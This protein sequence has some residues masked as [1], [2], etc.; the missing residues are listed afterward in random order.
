MKIAIAVITVLFAVAAQAQTPA[1]FATLDA[2]GKVTLVAG[3][4]QVTAPDPKDA[5]VQIT[6]T[7]R[8]PDR[9]IVRV[10]RFDPATGAQLGAND[11][12]FSIS[13]MEADIARMQA[14]LAAAQ[15]QLAK[16]KAVK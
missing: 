14:D 2:A 11:R 16:L 12:E 13:G 7:V 4:K 5:T 10:P 8:D 15:A 1:E 6:S 9:V 3:T